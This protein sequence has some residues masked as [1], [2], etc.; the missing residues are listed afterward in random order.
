MAYG[1]KREY[2]SK[3][4]KKNAKRFMEKVLY[5]F[6]MNREL[7]NNDIVYTKIKLDQIFY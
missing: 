5:F 3:G 1:E 7:H 6:G 2:R 4:F